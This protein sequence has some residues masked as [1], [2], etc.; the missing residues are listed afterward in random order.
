MLMGKINGGQHL[1]E[2]TVS[3]I[4]DQ[5]R[6]IFVGVAAEPLPAAMEQLLSQIQ[7]KTPS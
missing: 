3:M 2:N 5:L 1:P 6:A 7:R 4:A